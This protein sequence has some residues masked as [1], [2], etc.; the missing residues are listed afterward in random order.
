LCELLTQ[1]FD[2]LLE[3]LS[4]VVGLEVV[5]GECV[6]FSREIVGKH[7]ELQTPLGRGGTR[8]LRPTIVAR[9]GCASRDVVDRESLFVDDV[10]ELGGDSVELA[11][12]PAT[13]A[14]FLATLSQSLECVAD[15]LDVA[16]VAVSQTLLHDSSQRR[17]R[18]SVMDEFVADFLQ[19]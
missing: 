13:L 5:V 1:A 19:Q 8:H 17:V 15:S 16:A 11:A 4:R 7:V 12:E 18:I 3:A 2:E 10:V 14:D 9:V 6:D